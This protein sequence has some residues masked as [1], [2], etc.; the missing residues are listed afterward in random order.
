MRRWARCCAS[1]MFGGVGRCRGWWGRSR[2]GWD[3]ARTACRRVARR[4]PHR[5]GIE[6]EPPTS[7]VDTNM[8]VPAQTQQVLDVRF[9]AEVPHEQMVRVRP[10]KRH[11]I[12]MHRAQ[13]FQLVTLGTGPAASWRRD[14]VGR[15]C[16]AQPS[17]GRGLAS[18][19][20]STLMR[21]LAG[22]SSVISH[23]SATTR[24][25]DHES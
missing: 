4:V 22:V 1:V 19:R 21:A 11:L 16:W 14:H 8:V 10:V 15:S 7:F 25:D 18:S 12:H 17:H 23:G 13:V 5:G 6:G 24:S 9:T 3:R 2:F 20:R